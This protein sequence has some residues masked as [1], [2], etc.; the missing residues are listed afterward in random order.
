[1]K[2]NT[3][4]GFNRLN[5]SRYFFPVLMKGGNAGIIGSYLEGSIEKKVV[6]LSSMKDK[7]HQDLMTS[8]D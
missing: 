3:G 4:K 5:F 7:A 2:C 6:K 1:M 8:N